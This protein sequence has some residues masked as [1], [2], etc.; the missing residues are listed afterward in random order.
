MPFATPAP[1]SPD[2]WPSSRCADGDDGAGGPSGD[3][4]VPASRVRERPRHQRSVEVRLVPRAT[5]PPSNDPP[6]VPLRPEPGPSEQPTVP[7]TKR[8]RPGVTSS[9]PVAPRAPQGP[10]G[11]APVAPRRRPTGRGRAALLALVLGVLV[12]TATADVGRSPDPA[13]PPASTART[14][15]VP[16]VTAVDPAAAARTATATIDRLVQGRSTGHVSVAALDVTTGLSFGYAAD[17]PIQTAS[18]V[19]LDVLEALLL[20]SQDE[21]QAPSDASRAL[22]TRMIQ[23]SDNDAAS[24]LWEDLGGVPALDATNRRLGVRATHLVDH[25]GSSTTTASDQLAL[26]AALHAPIPLDPDSRS[27]ALDL[28]RNVVDEQRWGVSAAADAGTTTALK[29]GWAPV[30]SDDGRWVV[31]SVGI[32]T[33]AGTPVLLAVLTEHQPSKSAGIQLVEA[34]SRIAARAIT[35]RPAPIAPR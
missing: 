9:E 20:Q 19:K 6:T 13:P 5:A 32:V 7:E 33:A 2:R 34:L 30:D 24:R 18:V 17:T 35:T 10:S 8:R 27:F 26:L 3:L 4:D 23:Q 11:R 16:P 29:N 21:G 15:A 14:Q 12:A 31:G 25:W 22:A 28:M 1:G